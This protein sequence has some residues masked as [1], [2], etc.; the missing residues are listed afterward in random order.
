MPLLAIVFQVSAVFISKKDRVNS[1]AGYV[2]CCDLFPHNAS[3]KN[4]L[5]DLAVLYLSSTP[6]M[7]F[8]LHYCLAE[9]TNESMT[10]LWSLSV[11]YLRN[12]SFI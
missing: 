8:P 3:I 12:K 1:N 9:K 5:Y 10:L 7:A 11:E 6:A 4:H 2:S